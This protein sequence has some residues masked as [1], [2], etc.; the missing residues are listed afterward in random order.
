M[1]SFLLHLFGFTLRGSSLSCWLTTKQHH[2]GPGGEEPR[3]PANSWASESLNANLP[4]LLKVCLLVLADTWLQVQKDPHQESP[5]KL[6]L[7]SWFPETKITCHVKA[8]T[9]EVISYVA[10]YNQPRQLY[11]KT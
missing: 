7:N 6:L 2:G 4:A 10:K 9:F 5:A 8:L 3:A 11:Y 1:F